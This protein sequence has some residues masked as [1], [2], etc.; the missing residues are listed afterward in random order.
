M[1][2][3]IEEGLMTRKGY[4]I[5]KKL[6]EIKK[7]VITFLIGFLIWLIYIL[8]RIMRIKKTVR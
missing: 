4:R 8:R 6:K 7:T 3:K 5:R 1:K 2:K